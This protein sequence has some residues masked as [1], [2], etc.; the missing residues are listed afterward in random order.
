[1]DKKG[2]RGELSVNVSE[3]KM[4]FIAVKK[5]E[6][7]DVNEL[8]DFARQAYLRGQVT[9]AQYRDIVRELEAAGAYNPN[10][11]DKYVEL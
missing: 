6:P 3:L 8:L 10:C 9:I 5:Y 1:M 11:K 7:T 2:V 4:N